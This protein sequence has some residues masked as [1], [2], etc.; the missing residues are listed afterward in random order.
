LTALEDQQLGGLIMWIPAGVLLLIVSL[1]LFV[2][3]INHS[4]VRWEYTRVAA[5][6]RLSNGGVR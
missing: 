2:K 5:L 6:A 1:I 4:Q 3:W